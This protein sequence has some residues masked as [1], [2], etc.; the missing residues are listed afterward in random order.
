MRAAQIGFKKVWKY[1]DDNLSD[2]WK[3]QVP[4]VSDW[5]R[6]LEAE[7][8]WNDYYKNT[9]FRPRYPYRTYG[10]LGQSV[11]MSTIRYSSRSLKK[12]YG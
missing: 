6:A 2:Y 9:G 4:I 3:T 7:R 10:S 1:V 12:I 11:V 8:Y 5:N